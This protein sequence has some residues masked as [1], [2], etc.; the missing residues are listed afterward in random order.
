MNLEV[1]GVLVGIIS[2]LLTVYLE[3]DR[4]AVRIRRHTTRLASGSQSPDGKSDPAIRVSFEKT[5]IGVI[6]GIVVA[7]SLSALV[8]FC[9]LYTS[10][11]PRDRG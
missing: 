11:S 1:M 3:W 9:L 2:L 5:L 7:F 4:I 8:V 6:V 10:P